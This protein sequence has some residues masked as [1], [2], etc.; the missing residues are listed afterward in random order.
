[1][2]L[3]PPTDFLWQR[4][5]FQ[6]AVGG[7]GIIESPGLDYTLPYWMARYYGLGESIVVTSAAAPVSVVAPDSLGSIFG[8]NLAS[9]TE[10]ATLLPLPLSLG[11]LTLTVKDSAGATAIAP[12]LYVSP[13]QINFLMPSNLAVGIASFT[14]TG[15][16]RSPL[17]A[18]GAVGQVAPALFSLS[19]NGSGLAAATAIR[20]RAGNSGPASPVA[21]FDCSRSPCNA[22]PVDV[23]I[24]APVYLTLYCTGIRHRS[25]LDNVLVTINGISVPVLYAD[26][27]PD[28]AGLDQ[29]NVPLTL[30]LRGSGVANV[31]LKVDQHQANTVTVAVR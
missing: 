29:I 4:S 26:T 14:I 27:Q 8:P 19:G 23:G 13:S 21:L 7:A 16:A 18:I 9:A 12:L 1:V 25:S 30:D 22:L 17:T 28:F 10:Q 31:V 24:D 15:G 3:R 11:G 20:V 5:P 2:W 6:L